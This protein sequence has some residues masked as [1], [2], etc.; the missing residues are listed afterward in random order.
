MDRAALL[1]RQPLRWHSTINTSYNNKRQI[2]FATKPKVEAELKLLSSCGLNVL[3][4][5]PWIGLDFGE[6]DAVSFGP[7]MKTAEPQSQ[8]P[9]FKEKRKETID[10]ITVHLVIVHCIQSII[11]WVG[12]A[13]PGGPGRTATWWSNTRSY[14]LETIMILTL[15]WMDAWLT[16]AR[17]VTGAITALTTVKTMN[18][19]YHRL[20]SLNG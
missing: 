14:Y 3:H 11:R 20:P 7:R 10:F 8:I 6:P 9:T 13:R 12:Y 16:A 2:R 4:C 17:S 19:H 5:T 1:S 15:W 18:T